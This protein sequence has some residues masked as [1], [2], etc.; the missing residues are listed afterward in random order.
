MSKLMLIIRNIQITKIDTKQT[1]N[2]NTGIFNKTIQS[3]IKNSLRSETLHSGHC[4]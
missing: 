1:E 2:I 4:W 3:V